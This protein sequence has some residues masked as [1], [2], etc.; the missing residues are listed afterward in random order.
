MKL[1]YNWLKEYLDIPV[2]PEEL[3][4]ILTNLGLE[5][6]EVEEWE[7]VPGGLRGVVIGK[8]LTTVRHPDADKLTVNMVDTGGPEPVQ[9]VCGAPNVAPGQKVPVALPG[10]MVFK[11]NEKVEIR[12]SKIR[13]QLSE[14]MIC[15]EDE[16][17]LGTSHEGIMVLDPLVLPGTP[18]AEYFRIERDTVYTIG[19][20]PNRIDSG[21][22]FGAARDIAAYFNLQKKTE[23]AY[24]SLEEYCIDNHELVIGVEIENRKDCRRYSGLTI[25]GVTVSESPQWLRNRLRSVGL[26][27]INNIVDITNYVLLETGQPLHAFDADMIKGRKVVVRNMPAGTSFVT[28]DGVERKLSADDLMICNESEPMCIAGVFGGVG[29]GITEKT[30]NVF[31]E[32]A[33]FNPIAVRR[34]SRRHGLHTD[35]SFRFERGADI[36]ITVTALKRAALL[37]REIAGGKISS[38]IVDAYPVRT[39]VRRVQVSYRNINRL[40][41]KV[42]DIPIIRKILLSLDFI[43]ISESGEGM[44]LQIPNY[45]VDVSGEA[46]LVEEI[47][48]IYGYNNVETG[49]HLK[50][51]LSYIE[52][53]DREK[54]YNTIA[55]ML[56]A[57]GFNEMMSN[58]LVPSAWFEN[59]DDFEPDKIVRLANP[60]SS[61]LNA[62]RQSLLP[63][64]LSAIA[65][66]N[67]RQNFNLRL[68]EFGTCYFRDPGVKLSDPVS[69]Y[70]ER[71]DFD[72]F[73]TGMRTA[74]VWN[75]DD[76]PSDFFFLRSFLEMV[77]KR[78]GIDPDSTVK[79]SSDKKYFS[80][81]LTY[82]VGGRFLAS[83]GMISAQYL[84]K[85]D[86][87]QD[88][89]YGHIDW[90]TAISMLKGNTI[91]HRPLPRYPAVKRDLAL[92]VD[93]DMKYEELRKIAFSTEKIIL[94]EVGLFDVYEHESLG[95]GK[96]SYALSF[97]LRDDLRTLNEKN[98]EKIM[99]NLIR[100]FEKSAGA[101]V[102]K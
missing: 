44:E 40:V 14:G 53:P 18:A 13:G 95:K 102:R 84:E 75:S 82:S 1:S 76:K 36:D 57:N 48:R 2:S 73:I 78:L 61:D 88:V 100:A 12:R 51:T 20:T 19:L 26:N 80:E 56:A 22:H 58:S 43:V 83:A 85:F 17:G 90:G 38:D 49:E 72:L 64:G 81:S 93:S 35:A 94:R 91:L 3:S 55:D 23:A 52:K 9:I 74:K 98:I 5:V 24:P 31:L 10:T 101:T 66:N 30:V 7:S 8:V 46:D 89:C 39:P 67:N 68:F 42:I 97:V 21:S 59:N 25:S 32:S 37:I 33:W 87:K 27:P 63:G 16:L 41:G 6:E 70:S 11:E 96:K 60:L 47:L 15:A 29:S 45:R 86:I 28:L 77:L 62:M 69:S 71:K 99:N 79:G 65:W 34:T 4:E 50:S 54:A 92:L